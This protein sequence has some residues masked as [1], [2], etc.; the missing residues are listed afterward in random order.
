[1]AC[2]LLYCQ[3]ARREACLNFTALENITTGFG[4]FRDVK[5]RPKPTFNTFP[6]TVDTTPGKN[7]NNNIVYR[8]YPPV[9]RV[10]LV[11]M[12]DHTVHTFIFI[13]SLLGRAISVF[14]HI[15]L[16]LISIAS[17]TLS[18]TIICDQYV[19]K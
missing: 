19:Y 12:L 13:C 18:I 5:E 14:K 2:Q 11:I 16:H 3:E 1:M 4:N 15:Q 6:F 9:F 7:D 10:G 8:P 17:N